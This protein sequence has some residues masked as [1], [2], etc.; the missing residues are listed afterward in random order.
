MTGV[1]QEKITLTQHNILSCGNLDNNMA[2]R[3]SKAIG[4]STDSGIY[5]QEGG[6]KC[7]TIADIRDVKM[8]N[9]SFNF[10]DTFYPDGRVTSFFIIT[11]LLEG[12]VLFSCEKLS[13][14]SN[15]VT[16]APE[17]GIP[18]FYPGQIHSD[19]MNYD[20]VQGLLLARE[21]YTEDG[22]SNSED[23]AED[24]ERYEKTNRAKAENTGKSST[25]RWWAHGRVRQPL[26]GEYGYGRPRATE[27]AD[28][29][30]ISDPRDLPNWDGDWSSSM[31]ATSD[32]MEM[33]KSK[34]PQSMN[35]TIKEMNGKGNGDYSALDWLADL[36]IRNPN[37]NW[38]CYCERV[39]GGVDNLNV[40]SSLDSLFPRD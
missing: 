40:R 23:F 19:D 14:T 16:D 6:L 26:R 2:R 11:Y 20:V 33:F 7:D 1:R 13:C 12:T 8:R 34:F 37:G 39:I 9:F 25:S 22:V 30:W 24:Q 36:G 35:D 4:T 5:S 17:E 27:A 28:M 31:G 15:C 32:A 21:R 18:F 38:L 10:Y 29:G 3:P